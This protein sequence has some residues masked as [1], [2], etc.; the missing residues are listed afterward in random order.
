[1]EQGTS[2]YTFQDVNHLEETINSLT[3]QVNYIGQD[4][5]IAIKELK[6]IRS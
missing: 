6:E 4:Y 5:N 1:M 3:N 2:R